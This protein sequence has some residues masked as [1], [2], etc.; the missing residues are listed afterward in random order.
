M[1]DMADKTRDLYCC[2][3]YQAFRDKERLMPK[4]ASFVQTQTVYTK[5]HDLVS[6]RK[7]YS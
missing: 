3:R 4:F 1:I 6:K 5:T 2:G 7:L